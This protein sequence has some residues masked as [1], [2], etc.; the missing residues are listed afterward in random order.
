M[1]DLEV[2]QPLEHGF[3]IQR[4]IRLGHEGGSKEE[5]DDAGG[6]THGAR[7]DDEG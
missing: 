4:D 6:E 5:E 2:P 3:D 7:M 1:L